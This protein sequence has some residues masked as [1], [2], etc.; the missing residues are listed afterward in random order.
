MEI[1]SAEWLD[2]VYT[3]SNITI[4]P[5]GMSVDGLRHTF[6]AERIGEDGNPTPFD[7][8]VS[9]INESHTDVK[10][11]YESTKG[12][13]FDRFNLGA[14]L[15]EVREKSWAHPAFKEAFRL[16]GLNHETNHRQINLP[17]YNELSMGELSHQVLGLES[18]VTFAPMHSF[19]I[20]LQRNGIK[21][22]V[23]GC[24]VDG[25]IITA[26]DSNS[27]NGY[28]AVGIRGGSS[29]PNTYHVVAAGGLKGTPELKRGEE[30]IYDVFR[31]TELAAE[32]GDFTDERIVQARP[33]A[34]NVEHIIN[35]GG[36]TYL[37]KVRTNLSKEEIENFWV[38]AKDKKEHT[39]IVFVPAHSDAVNDF[40][41]QNYRGIVANKQ[42]RP[43][44]ERY[45]LSPGALD[46]AAYAG[47][48][49]NKLRLLH[50]DGEW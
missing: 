6:Q 19:E 10:A 17:W 40:I 27:S 43:D 36:V 45:L 16:L 38:T 41:A 32:L 44:S 1:G 11:W 29:F 14:D 20:Q 24:S 18:I 5:K 15:A 50:Q 35:K 7:E 47:M 49:P 22:P 8:V 42:D 34:R 37:F 26:P 46:L 23:N 39:G 13:P 31:R 9:F 33:L 48:K 25:I 4:Y 12:R 3:D 30:S 2:K 21:V 28:V